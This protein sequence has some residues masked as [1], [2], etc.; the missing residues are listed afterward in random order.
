MVA[1][2]CFLAG[3]VLRSVLNLEIAIKK[4]HL[5]WHNSNEGN[6]PKTADFLNFA[7]RQFTHSKFLWAN[8]SV[9]KVRSKL[10]LRK[11]KKKNYKL[12]ALNRHI[13]PTKTL[14]RSFPVSCHFDRFHQET[15]GCINI[16]LFLKY[17]IV[18]LSSQLRW[19]ST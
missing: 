3:Q 2:D 19:L 6:Q 9:K 17:Y 7:H 13:C 14:L 15:L 11:K 4:T 12:R 1:K 8:S 16:R 10:F 18:M 5:N